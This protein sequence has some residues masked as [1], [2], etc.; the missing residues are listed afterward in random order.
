MRAASRRMMQRK[1]TRSFWKRNSSDLS[2]RTPL[3]IRTKYLSMAPKAMLS[4][5]LAMAGMNGST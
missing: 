1:A 4:A 2:K 5:V 3:T